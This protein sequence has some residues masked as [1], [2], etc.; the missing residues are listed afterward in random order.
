MHSVQNSHFGQA[1]FWPHLFREEKL[2]KR[3]SRKIVARICDISFVPVVWGWLEADIFVLLSMFGLVIFIRNSDYC[4]D[5]PSMPLATQKAASPYL[6]KECSLGV[7]LN[8]AGWALC[9]TISVS[10]IQE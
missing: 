6:S 5:L 2:K 9:L 8:S 1:S 4:Q 3:L 10:S 7:C